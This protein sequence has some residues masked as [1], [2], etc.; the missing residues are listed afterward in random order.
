M[1]KQFKENLIKT[2]RKF[3]EIMLKL[4]EKLMKFYS[5]FERIVWIIRNF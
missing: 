5:N 3:D 1:F 2:Y 4:S